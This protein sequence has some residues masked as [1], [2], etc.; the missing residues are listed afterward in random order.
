MAKHKSMHE[1]VR[2]WLKRVA[3]RPNLDD[4]LQQVRARKRVTQTRIP[5]RKILASRNADRP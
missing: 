4:W 2:E 1:L 5:A 3:L